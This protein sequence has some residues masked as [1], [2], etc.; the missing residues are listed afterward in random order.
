MDAAPR[1]GF[2]ISA[3]WTQVETTDDLRPELR[4]MDA[5]TIQG[6]TYRVNGSIVSVHASTKAVT[7]VRVEHEI[8]RENGLSSTSNAKRLIHGSDK[9]L[10]RKYPIEATCFYLDRP[11][12]G[13]SADA[14]TAYRE[15]APNDV[16]DLW[17]QT[18]GPAA[19]KLESVQNDAERM[20]ND[21]APPK[22][23]VRRARKK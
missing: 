12:E 19:Q 11:F 15:G 8:T 10:R 23:R 7:A 17:A 4:S 13:K 5:V 1:L 6:R 2:D 16:R 22:K 18:L 14:E 9:G 20:A 3:V 21:N